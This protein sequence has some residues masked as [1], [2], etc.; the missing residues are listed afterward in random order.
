MAVGVAVAVV[1]V[2]SVLIVFVVAVVLVVAVAVAVTPWLAVVA[3]VG[4]GCLRA[5]GRCGGH[6]RRRGR[7]NGCD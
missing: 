6:D 1:I 2:M 4:S 3:V 7:G 5:R